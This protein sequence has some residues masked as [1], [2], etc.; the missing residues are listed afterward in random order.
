VNLNFITRVAG[1]VKLAAKAHAPTI[2]VT[3]GVVSMGASVIVASKQ[4]LTLD[5]VLMDHVT[6]LEKI[7]DGQTF[8]KTQ[9][10]SY[11]DELA[12]QDRIKVYTR[13]SVDVTKHYFIPGVLFVGGA[14]LVFGGHR[15]MLKRNATLAIA[16]TT[17]AKAFDAYRERVRE[18]WGDE[19]DQAMMGGYVTKE[20]YDDS[21]KHA[22]EVNTRDW[23]DPLHGN[24]YA[25]VFEQGES[26]QWTRD[27][28]TNT[29]FIANQ[30]RFAQELL[31]RRGHLFLWEVYEA[32][33][34]EPND[35]SRVTGWKV[36]KLA[37]GTKDIP[38]VDFGL[39]KEMPEDWKVNSN[40]GIF[41]DINCQGLIVGG[42]VQKILESAR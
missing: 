38:V 25:R 30:Q 39:D 31:G 21:K 26:S 16:Y 19:T 27:H 7:E 1:A 22:V 40:G 4:T 15:I 5:A 3:T 28:Y 41:L 6:N 42:K 34:F 36:R 10:I 32:L 29:M 20:V 35:I 8:A 13:A 14:C 17:V 23:D 37:D 2:M 18:H 9:G 11:T 12:R 24:P 33:G